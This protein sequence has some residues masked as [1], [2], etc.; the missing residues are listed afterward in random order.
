MVRL[1]KE[2]PW[3]TLLHFLHPVCES[4]AITANI[5]LFLTWAYAQYGRWCA[6]FYCSDVTRPYSSDERL[7]AVLFFGFDKIMTLRIFFVHKCRFVPWGIFLRALSLEQKQFEGLEILSKIWYNR[8]EKRILAFLRPCIKGP[9]DYALMIGVIG[10][11]VNIL[12]LIA[13]L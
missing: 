13:S 5:T 3:N 10:T 7:W 9:E 2:V 12:I 1:R 11:A 6:A 4:P 8:V